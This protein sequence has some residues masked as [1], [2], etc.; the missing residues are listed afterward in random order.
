M[1]KE[2]AGVEIDSE[3]K[4]QKFFYTCRH[5]QV[6]VCVCMC[7]QPFHTYAHSTLSLL[8]HVNRNVFLAREK[9]NLLSTHQL[10]SSFKVSSA[11][12]GL[13][14]QVEL[15]GCRGNDSAVFS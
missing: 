12:Y 8:S 1:M 15:L 9:K 4:S 11:Y 5:G 7:S 3:I 10:F 2:F 13:Y 6:C 14:Q